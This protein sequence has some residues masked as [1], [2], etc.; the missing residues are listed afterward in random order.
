[1]AANGKS[2]TGPGQVS[3]IFSPQNVSCNPFSQFPNPASPNPLRQPLLQPHPKPPKTCTSVQVQPPQPLTPKI[4]C[5]VFTLPRKKNQNPTPR[6][7]AVQGPQ[8]GPNP[9]Q[10]DQPAPGFHKWPLGKALTRAPMEY[11]K[12][13]CPPDFSRTGTTS[14]RDSP[15][16]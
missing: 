13:N 11:F 6:F 7:S 9:L 14:P 12:G 3:D 16:V 10:P 2:A 15:H 8:P 5:K 4:P 1:M